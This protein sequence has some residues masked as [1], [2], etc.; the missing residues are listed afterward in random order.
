[1]EIKRLYLFIVLLVLS[2]FTLF[3][4]YNEEDWT[5]RDSWMKVP[6]LMALAD[7]GAGDTVADIGCHEG[8]FSFHLSREV[9]DS[10]K[11]YAVDVQEYRLEE[12]KE[13]IK[14]REVNNIEVIL[15]EEDNPK[16]PENELDVAV[17]MDTYHEMEH[18]RKILSHIRNALK[19]D[20]RL[21]VLEKLKEYKRGKSREEQA[22][23]HTLSSDYVKK[24]LEESGFEVTK[25]TRDFGLWK[26]E[27]DKQIWILVAMPRVD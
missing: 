7:V 1:M 5:E 11:V 24:E 15:G 2:T 23:A 4:Q 22:S 13:H 17:V 16:L 19:P 25:E 18:Y 6:E 21:L 20:G 12:L 14:E 9:G 10:G 26:N 3:A 8:Y 27:S